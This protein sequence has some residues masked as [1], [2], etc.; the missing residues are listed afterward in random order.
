MDR[1]PSRI[2]K[3]FG[4]IAPRYDFLNH[5]LSCGIDKRWRKRVVRTLDPP[6]D[7]KILDVCTGT[8]DLALDFWRRRGVAVTGCDFCE[9]M[10]EIGR[11]KVEKAGAGEKI[12]LRFAD[13]M[14]LPFGDDAYDFVTV[15][16][17]L[18]NIQDP[19]RGLAEMVRVCR[20]GG[21]VAVLEFSTPTM[22]PIRQLY[23][24]Y[25]RR[26]LPR[27]G[28][29]VARNRFDAYHYLPASVSE[30]PQ[31]EQLTQMMENAGLTQTAFRPLTFGIATLYT[32]VKPLEAVRK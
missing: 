24:F 31:G 15:A 1:T 8:G 22:F 29:L 3:M 25:F 4:E 18:R 11:K 23:R 19:Q 10:L 32:G 28:Q 26:I 2:Q 14:N 13:A 6:A 9:E 21:M 12:E 5:V 16:F 17:G 30:F 20:P 7:A 27:V